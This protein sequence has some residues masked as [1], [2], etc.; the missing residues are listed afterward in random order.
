VPLRLAGA[1]LA[2][3]VEQRLPVRQA[4]QDLASVR[5]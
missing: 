2:E 1:Q 3:P 5:P 4:V